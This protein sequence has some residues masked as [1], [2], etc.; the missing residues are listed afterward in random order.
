MGRLI[1]YLG[2]HKVSMIAIIAL[3][4]VQAYCDLSLPGYTSDIVDIGIGQSGIEYA[5]FEEVSEETLE[6][7]M[8]F[9]SE[10]EV[11]VIKKSYD[12]NEDN[13]NLILNEYGEENIAKLD[14][15]MSSSLFFIASMSYMDE[16]ENSELNNSSDKNVESNNI[17][18]VNAE[19][20]NNIDKNV[21]SNN[22]TNDNADS[23]IG[24]EATDNLLEDDGITVLNEL[25]IFKKALEDQSISKEFLVD[26][27]N[28]AVNALGDMGDT[29]I[30]QSAVMS[31]KN[32]YAKIGVDI[33]EIQNAYLFRVGL[34][35]V[36]MTLLMM[37]V[38]ILAGLIASIVSAKIGMNLRGRVFN[39]V[40]SFSNNELNHFSSASLITRSTND[41]QQIQMVSVMLLRMV[42]YAP[43][44]GIGGVIKVL[45]TNT[46]LGWII[47]VGV[48]TILFVVVTLMVIAMPKF[49]AMQV[50]V[51]KLNLVSREIVTG[52]P[53]IRAFSRQTHE[54]KRFDKANKD[55]MKT[56]LFTNRVMTFM[57]PI[58]MLIMNTLTL[59][60]VW[61]GA[62]KIDA[63]N[64]QV[65]EMMAFITYTMQIVMSFLMLTFIAVLVPRAAVSAA[66]V[67]E[68]INTKESIFD[69]KEPKD[70][71]LEN[72]V[73]RIEFRD[74]EFRYNGADENTIENIS[75]VAEPGKTTAIIGSTGSGKS[76][77]L[78]LIPRFFDVTKGGIYIDGVDIREITQNKLRSI[79]GLIPQKG[80]LFSGNIESNIKFAG[81]F[82]SDE[83]MEK[84][85][86]IAQALE[87]VLE[88]ED[89]FKSEI[90]QGGTNVSGGQKQRLAIA[91]AIAKDP[92]IFLFDDSFSALDYKTDTTLR[93]AIK[94][95]I[96][97]ATVLVVAQRIS[98]ILHADK[99]LVLDDGKIVGSGTH[100]ELLLNCKEYGEI[101]SSQLSEKELGVGKE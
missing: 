62:K 50:L 57:M 90:S 39:K 41:I 14:K 58:M 78:N 87:F 72:V 70:E 66:R 30:I 69:P 88:K 73:G 92:K 32:E 43:I 95:N 33:D 75:F 15:I 11:E 63:G 26:M 46:G 61:F 64:M 49:K 97:G 80:N 12:L 76:T 101:A 67:D 74:V 52:V 27:K 20:N 7:I 93:K 34:M 99:I 47:G 94:E 3:L 31:I 44:L 82:V 17:P 16:A 42:A 86:K 35:M 21:E 2:E 91:R 100:E 96:K 29:I 85:A 38:S 13:G 89:G 68:V 81:D 54:E 84:A 83:M 45:N 10:E 37:I 8:L 1:K 59:M 60:V 53:V 71:A 36:L 4:I 48:G 65:G 9:S 23:N 5:V 98:T 25:D 51:D 56:Q 77:L 6:N 79:I 22:I 55:L 40:V 19:S 28:E 24:F 18:E